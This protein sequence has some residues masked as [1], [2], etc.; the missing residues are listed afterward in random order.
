MIFLNKYKVFSNAKINIGLNVFEKNEDG[1]HDIDSIMVPVT[2]ADEME[3]E[4]YNESGNLEIECSEKKIPTDERNILYKA[5]KVFFENIETKELKIK[6][7]LKKNIPSEAGLGGG[8]SNAA[9]F[10]KVLNEYSG[11]IYSLEELEKISMRIGSDVPFFIKNKTARVGGKGEKI[12]EV[13]NNL[14]DGLILIKPEFGVSTKEA[15]N[16]FDNLDEKKYS[17]FD[18]IES[19]LKTNNRVGIE[20]NIE[21]SLEQAIENNIDIKMLKMTLNAV[22]PNKR[23]F[24]SGSGSTYYTFVTETE[25]AQVETRLKTFVDNVKII[26][27]GI[28]K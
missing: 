2:L 22:L 15:Y 10:L 27:C 7:L 8:S 20:K 18:E 24:M 21:N 16:N 12:R 28:K 3:I 11:N 6:V 23:F 13:E 14:E 26:I 1:Y 25:R 17:N 19:C 5:Y 4:I 9:F